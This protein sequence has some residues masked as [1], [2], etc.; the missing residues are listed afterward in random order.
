MTSINNFKTKTCDVQLF[1]NCLINLI[2]HNLKTSNIL[3]DPC[4]KAVTLSCAQQ[5]PLYLGIKVYHSFP[6]FLDNGHKKSCSYCSKIQMEKFY[7][8]EMLHKMQSELQTVKTL[9]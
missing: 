2:Q 5:V 3:I 9:I 4:E 8:R 6:K 7:H 1:R